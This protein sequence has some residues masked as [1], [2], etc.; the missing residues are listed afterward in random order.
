MANALRINKNIRTIELIE[1]CSKFLPLD[2]LSP[3]EGK[4]IYERLDKQSGKIKIDFPTPKTNNRWLLIAQGWV[5]H[6][7][8]TPTLTIIVNPKI[9]LNNLFKIIEYAYRLSSQSIHFTSGIAYCQ[10]FEE[11]YNSLVKYF[12]LKVAA[13]SKKGFYKTYVPKETDLP[14]LKGRCTIS[15]L[16]TA[17]YH[18][19]FRCK[20]QENT[21]DNKYNQIIAWALYCTARNALCDKQI[22]S[23]LRRTYEKL[24]GIVTLKALYPLDCS[25]QLYNRLNQDYQQLHALSRF[26]LENS[27]PTHKIGLKATLPFLIEMPRLFELFVAEWLKNNL[28]NGMKVKYLE[29]FTTGREGIRFEIDIVIYDEKNKPLCVIDTKYKT[30]VTKPDINQIRTYAGAKSCKNAILVYPQTLDRPLNTYIGKVKVN[31]L[32]FPLKHDIEAS[33]EKFLKNFFQ[34]LSA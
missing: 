32:A 26:F 29:R 30:E 4:I 28:K 33:G 7:P 24:A 18:L 27:A 22:I 15:S 2:V 3:R 31:S 14:Y 34:C 16:L 25:N 13:R 8:V 17:Q 9:K 10:S 1:Y 11:F 6:I 5:G 20:F 21:V 12:A 23:L 19:K